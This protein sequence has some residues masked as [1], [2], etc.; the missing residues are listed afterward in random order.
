MKRI[1]R[2]YDFKNFQKPSNKCLSVLVIDITGKAGIE[3]Q[4]VYCLTGTFEEGIKS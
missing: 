1:L 3:F 4:L 2:L